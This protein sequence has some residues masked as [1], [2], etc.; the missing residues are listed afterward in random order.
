MT[1]ADAQIE[2]AL[3]RSIERQADRTAAVLQRVV[4]LLG[5]VE[6]KK[7]LNHADY[8]RRTRVQDRA[9]GN[10]APHRRRAG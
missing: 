5:A 10:H 4:D 1:Y 6:E 9:P 3:L 8:N 7:G 2:I